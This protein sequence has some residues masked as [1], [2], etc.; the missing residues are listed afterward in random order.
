VR[1]VVTVPDNV[2]ATVELPAGTR[3]YAASGA[4]G[5]RYAGIQNGRAVYSV[6]SGTTTFTPRS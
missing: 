2:Q 6:G 3:P 5:P 1:L 4:G